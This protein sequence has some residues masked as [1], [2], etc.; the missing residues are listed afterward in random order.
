[1]RPRL[2]KRR[3]RLSYDNLET[4]QLLATISD[5]VIPALPDSG[6]FLEDTQ[7]ESIARK[8]LADDASTAILQ[9]GISDLELVEIQHGLASTV[10]RFQQTL[11]GVPVADAYVTTIQGPTGDFVMVHDQSFRGS[12]DRADSSTAVD[13]ATTEQIALDYAGA[14][15]TFAPSRGDLVW[16]PGQNGTAEQV[17]QVTVFGVTPETHGDFLTYIEPISEKVLSQEN[18]ISHF[19]TGDGEVFYPNP[20]QTLGSGTG[21]SDNGDADSAALTNQRVSV[22]L[23][24]LDDGTGLLTGEFVDLA[25]L[26]S[27]SL[28]D[29]DANEPTRD[30][31]Y[32]RDDDNL[33][34]LLFTTPSISSIDTF[35]CWASTMTPVR[36]TEYG[37][38]LRWPTRIGIPTT[39]RF[40]RQVTMRFIL[41]T[42]V[43]TMAKMATSSLMSLAMQFSTTKM[44]LGVAA[45][46]APWAKDLA[47]TWPPA[48]FKRLEM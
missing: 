33:N 10:T 44:R 31:D 35:M 48:F 29:V 6:Y 14:T 26:N 4:R 41:V 7:Q 18:R 11:L 16:L 2:P 47:T 19:T 34:K 20:Y 8:H 32:T 37:T 5:L 13:F 39:N 21:I 28:P 45:K 27:T 36:P 38:F 25:T 9:T 15:S 24:G 40:I 3:S 23:E 46:W 43:S 30:Y 22:T 42:V 17:W 12:F 1:M